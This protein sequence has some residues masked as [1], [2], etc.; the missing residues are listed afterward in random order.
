MTNLMQETRLLLSAL[1]KREDVNVCTTFRWVQRGVAGV[2]L[3]SFARGRSRFTTVEAFERWVERVT[4]A[5]NGQ[6]P[7]SSSSH[8]REHEKRKARTELI[9]ARLIEEEEPPT[10]RSQA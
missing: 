1:A 4:A 10:D 5:K 3:E 7:P 8:Q 9:E 6:P 2:R